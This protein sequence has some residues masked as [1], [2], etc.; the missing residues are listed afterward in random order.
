[1]YDDLFNISGRVVLK[2]VREGA[3]KPVACGFMIMR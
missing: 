2:K 1:M 3:L